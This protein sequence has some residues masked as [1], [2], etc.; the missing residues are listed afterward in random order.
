MNHPMLNQYETAAT[1]L[2]ELIAGLSKDQ[3]L[4][5]PVPGT[6]SVQENVCHIVDTDLVIADRMKRV[7][8]E[9]NP[10]LLA[11]DEN[12]WTAHLAYAAQDATDAVTLLDANHRQMAR[13][14]RALPDS[15]MDRN[16]T[17]NQA[18]PLT[19]RDLFEKSVTHL[20]HHLKNALAKRNII[21]KK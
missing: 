4:A 12:R 20:E 18:G 3:L 17:H 9:D 19:L 8:A 21:Q 1:G 11:F 13:V 6:W 10:T 7:I 2:R 14:L 15:A 16:G 5:H